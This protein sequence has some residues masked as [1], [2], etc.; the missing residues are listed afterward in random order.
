MANV[1]NPSAA[2]NDDI[3]Q[4]V[5]VG[6]QAVNQA[7]G[8][9]ISAGQGLAQTMQNEHQM[10]K[11]Y[12]IEQRKLDLQEQQLKQQKLFQTLG[13]A[14]DFAGL[15]T[16]AVFGGIA[17]DQAGQSLVT[18]GRR[19]DQIDREW[20]QGAQV[21]EAAADV[22]RRWA[23]SNGARDGEAEQNQAER[24]AVRR[25]HGRCEQRPRSGV[26]KFF[27]GSGRRHRKGGRRL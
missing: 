25:Q 26:N 19:L 27:C 16:G 1:L 12:R 14:R 11:Q 18:E 17:A 23:T 7:T 10:R 24:P 2:S 21:G 4:A 15:A 6:S 5:G 8:N 3:A 20:N 9:A 22:N 13:M